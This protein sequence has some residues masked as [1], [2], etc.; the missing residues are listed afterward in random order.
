M[1]YES[2]FV[3]AEEISKS[4]LYIYCADKGE[5]KSCLHIGKLKILITPKFSKFRK[6]MYKIFFGLELEKIE[7]ENNARRKR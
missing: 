2:K 1:I 6:L 4:P 5:L 7:E 3:T